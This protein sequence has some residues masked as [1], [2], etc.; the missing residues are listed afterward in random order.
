MT[1]QSRYIPTFSFLVVFGAF[2]GCAEDEP[3]V[4][5]ALVG[6]EDGSSSLPVLP[7]PF[8]AEETTALRAGFDWADTSELA[9]TDEEGRPAYYY[10]N[11]LVGS[12]EQADVLELARVYHDAMP[13]FPEELAAWEDAG[14][15]TVDIVGDDRGAFVFALLPGAVYNEIRRTALAGEPAFEVVRLREVPDEAAQ[16]PGGHL[17]LDVLVERG[18][19]FGLTEQELEPDTAAVTGAIGRVEAPLFGRLVRAIIRIGRT[20]ANTVRT[21]VA[22]VRLKRDF[23]F[24]MRVVNMDP[25]F[26]GA[27]PTAGV[28]VSDDQ[29]LRQGWGSNAGTPV[30]PHGAIIVVRTNMGIT[31]NEL[32]SLGE[33]A[34]RVPRDK[35]FSI[36]LRLLNKAAVITAG[37]VWEKR[38]LLGKG[39][40]GESDRSRPVHVA[41]DILD[42]S[43][44]ELALLTE[45]RDFAIA[46][47]RYVPRQAIVVDGP[48]DTRASSCP[49]WS[50]FGFGTTAFG[51]GKG[52]SLAAAVF[53]IFSDHDMVIRAKDGENRGVVAHE[54]GHFLMC[55]MFHDVSRRDFG[56]AYGEVIHDVVVNSGDVLPEDDAR[57]IAEGWAD[58]Y[59]AQ[60]VGGTDYFDTYG[61]RSGV[62]DDFDDMAYC[63]QP[64]F[65]PWYPCTEDNVG[66]P[67]G[68][69]PEMVSPISDDARRSIGT[70]ATLMV[71]AFDRTTVSP[72]A[73]NA[74]VRWTFTPVAPANPKPGARP[75]LGAGLPDEVVSLEGSQLREMVE[76]WSDSYN[77]LRLGAF[78]NAIAS[79]LLRRFDAPDVCRVFELHDPSRDCGALASALTQFA[80]AFDLTASAR[81]DAIAWT[82]VVDGEWTLL[83]PSA[84]HAFVELRVD[85][86]VVE[87]SEQP[88]SMLGSWSSTVPVA[89]DSAAELR[90]APSIGSGPVGE[91]SSRSLQTPPEP[92]TVV[93]ASAS[94]YY[95]VTVS[96]TATKATSYRVWTKNTRTGVVTWTET[97]GTHVQISPLPEDTHEFKV[98]SVNAVGE[99]S[100]RASPTVTATPY[101]IIY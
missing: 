9:E 39:N 27:A 20:I 40:F 15:G 98:Y 76:K 88:Y 31:M 3:I 12:R 26:F 81:L 91:L 38:I 54:Y 72:S 53:R 58:F 60:V 32:S 37:T 89:F 5:Y 78:Y 52:W 63:E 95:S 64:R 70:F 55:D 13:L 75:T 65:G 92:V 19:T 44:H 73:I 94:D 35:S 49:C 42:R 96:W 77:R 99:V 61:A 1:R 45:A 17:D 82:A 87:T 97:T 48:S 84:T 6:S 7:P 62:G 85:G 21:F 68:A 24:R 36:F 47:L 22:I 80:P 50:F 66:G 71:D 101:V 4:D 46:Q 90:V 43:V 28:A 100:T 33:V 59:A 34:M 67:K 79:V 11:I 69:F 16:R 2:S 93:N 18:C 8:T 14:P 25:L 30:V 86:A 41:R 29:I 83:D 51:K 74:G 23:S 56:R 57:I 10:A